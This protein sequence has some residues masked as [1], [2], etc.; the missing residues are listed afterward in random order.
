MS[1]NFGKTPEVE[2]KSRE[3][4]LHERFHFLSICHL[5]SKKESS[6]TMVLSLCQYYDATQDLFVLNDDVKFTL[7]AEEVALVLSI[8]NSGNDVDVGQIV[9]GST[10]EYALDLRKHVLPDSCDRSAPLSTA[11]LKAIICG[12]SVSSEESKLN[13]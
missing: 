8:R 1:C 3:K 4:G 7:C 13:F 11:D 9:G 2:I 10:P 5:S 6:A 12:M